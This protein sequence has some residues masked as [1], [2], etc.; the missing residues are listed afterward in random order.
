[1]C[2]FIMLLFA[3]G[4]MFVVSKF[5]EILKFE[6]NVGSGKFVFVA[7]ASFALCHNLVPSLDI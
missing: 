7:T 3:S 5:R 1:M 6:C 4:F 2:P